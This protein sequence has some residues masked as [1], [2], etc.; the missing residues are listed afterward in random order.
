MFHHRNLD[1]SQPSG[2]RD[3]ALLL[4]SLAQAWPSVRL[5]WWGKKTLYCLSYLKDRKASFLIYVRYLPL[6]SL[7]LGISEHSLL[8]IRAPPQDSAV[9]VLAEW[10]E[11]SNGVF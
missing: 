6:Y 1:A 10:Y 3:P 5:F 11:P 2:S 4:L 9:P 7:Y 8:G